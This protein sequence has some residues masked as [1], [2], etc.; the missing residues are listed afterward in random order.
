MVIDKCSQYKRRATSSI[1]LFG[2]RVASGRSAASTRTVGGVSGGASKP[3]LMVSC[4]R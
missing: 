3:N 1:A 4:R 2:E